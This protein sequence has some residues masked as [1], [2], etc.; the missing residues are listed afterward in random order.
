[1]KPNLAFFL[2]IILFSS[3]AGRSRQLAQA[4]KSPCPP[5]SSCEG[6]SSPRF[7]YPIPGPETEDQYRETIRALL[8]RRDF[9]E[10]DQTA[11][12][13]RL[14]KERMGGGVWKLYVFYDEA[15]KPGPGERLPAQRWLERQA[16]LNEWVAARPDSV[17]A[18]VAL[19]DF[20]HLYAWEARGGGYAGSV[21]APAWKLF[22]TRT[23]RAYAVLIEAQKLA[24]K[25]P[26][27][28]FVMLDVARDQNWSKEQ[29]RQLFDQAEQ[30]YGATPLKLNRF[31]MLAFL[32]CDRVSTS[33]LLARIGDSWEPKVWVTRARF[34]QARSWAGL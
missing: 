4:D 22:R 23:E 33:R 15:A 24:T 10:L 12:N 14:S 26:Q 1:M 19:A 18:R 11:T 16:L 27:W 31:T 25:C 17:T 13:A 29:M 34:D 8:D 21:T 2:S 5:A 3:A 32:Y 20:Y 6:S 7:L 30:R 9:A 28:Y